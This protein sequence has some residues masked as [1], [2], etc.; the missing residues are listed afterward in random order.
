MNRAMAMMGLLAGTSV[1][2]AWAGDGP[3]QFEFS[4]GPGISAGAV[5]YEIGGTVLQDGLTDSAPFPISRLEWP[6]DVI[7][8]EFD[9]GLLLAGRFELRGR[10]AMSL[11]EDAGTM[12]DSDWDY[13]E[14]YRVLSVYSES[15][16]VLDAWTLDLSARWWAWRQTRPGDQEMRL[17]IGAGWLQQNFEWEARDGVQTYPSTPGVPADTWEGTA[18]TYD[19][20]AELP[21]LELCA[22]IRQPKVTIEGRVA[23]IP[24]AAVTD[25]DDHQLRDILADTDADGMGLVAEAAVRVDLTERVF[26]RFRAQYIAFEVDGPSRNRVYG[27]ENGEDPVGTT[28]EIDEEIHSAQAWFSA[29]I[30]LTL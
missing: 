25:R 11:T 12:V 15:D 21:Y 13:P 9:A 29:G 2:G 23:W 24:S 18:I 27:D 14:G 17:G 30:G 26:L 22:S 16:A 1:A 4:A 28:W 8:A 19:I 5:T 20:E 7:T 10:Y 3:V 6:L